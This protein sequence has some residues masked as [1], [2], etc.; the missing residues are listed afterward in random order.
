MT[1]SLQKAAS[2]PQ[3]V[4]SG[5]TSAA[6]AAGSTKGSSFQPTTSGPLCQGMLLVG[7]SPH[8]ASG[9]DGA[10]EW[11]PFCFTHHA[12][13]HLSFTGSKAAPEYVLDADWRKPF[14][15]L[16][17]KPVARSR[18]AAGG[19]ARLA[20]D[21]N[22]SSCSAVSASGAS[23]P[24][25]TPSAGGRG[26][27]R[28]DL[29]PFT[30]SYAPLPVAPGE[31]TAAAPVRR[32]VLLAASSL[33]SRDRWLATFAEKDTSGRRL[34][35]LGQRHTWLPDAT[36]QGDAN[37][38]QP[39]REGSGLFGAA[40]ARRKRLAAGAAGIW[41]AHSK[42]HIVR[43]L[44]DTYAA[45]PLGE[46]DRALAASSGR[47]GLTPSASAGSFPAAMRDLGGCD[48]LE[49]DEERTPHAAVSRRLLERYVE[50][51]E[52]IERL[53]E[54]KTGHG[55]IDLQR[56]GRPRYAPPQ[57][58][59]FEQET[60]ER[61]ADDAE[62]LAGSQ[63]AS[64]EVQLSAQGDA[65]VALQENA[66]PAEEPP[67]PRLAER[68]GL[69]ACAMLSGCV[70]RNGD[71]SGGALMQP[72]DPTCFRLSI[73]PLAPVDY[74]PVFI[75][76]APA[77]AVLDVV[78]FFDVGGAVTL[79]VG[80][81]ASEALIASMGASGGRPSFHCLGERSVSKLPLLPPGGQ[82][83]VQYSEEPSAHGGKP[84]GQVTFFVTDEDGELHSARP[85]M[86]RRLIP[87][88]WRPC[89]LLCMPHTKVLIEELT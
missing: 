2:L 87:G 8:D 61:D 51:Q 39:R 52:K 58:V 77:D 75:G 68:V 24:S 13:G 69:T 30:L 6:H 57:S 44:Y 59:Y 5:A 76:I 81:L 31:A 63:E 72:S 11:Q 35:S 71:W 23:A 16:P 22:A 25:L 34:A 78:N 82:L 48:H 28:E 55:R 38:S 67:D 41:D 19:R 65:E 4:V 89:V 17:W 15:A 45:D 80:G 47:R 86:K 54:R 46:V 32:T 42:L 12:D 70:L 7:R 85:K 33:A 79:C 20:A 21:E 66:E 1:V 27:Q 26:G 18:A 9:S 88:M 62:A 36:A 60:G 64:G 73:R 29:F 37:S 74:A 53:L 14:V 3:L 83:T 56:P 43:E 84:E 40:A 10:V 49:Q 50:R